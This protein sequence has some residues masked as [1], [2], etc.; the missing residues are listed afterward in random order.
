MRFAA[1]AILIDSEKSVKEVD[2]KPDYFNIPF[3]RV[4]HMLAGFAHNL[5][6]LVAFTVA[7]VVGVTCCADDFFLR[8]FP[9][10]EQT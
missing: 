3:C 9:Q 8:A 10:C 5:A 6:A 1:F 7:V 2:D 4:A